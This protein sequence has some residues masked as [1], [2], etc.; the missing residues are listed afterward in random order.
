MTVFTSGALCCSGL[1]EALTHSQ[2]SSEMVA[3]VLLKPQIHSSL[4][5]NK[6]LNEPHLPPGQHGAGE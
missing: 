1:A 5:E 4:F 6:K 2:Q 3:L